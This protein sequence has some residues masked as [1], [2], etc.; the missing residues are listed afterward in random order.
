MFLKHIGLNC[1]YC[2]FPPFQLGGGKGLG[3]TSLILNLN[4][5]FLIK[6]LTS[7]HGQALNG[8]RMNFDVL[9][10]QSLQDHPGSGGHCID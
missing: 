1:M 9:N 7:E 2:M 8:I 6:K 3:L 5:A 4:F 10:R